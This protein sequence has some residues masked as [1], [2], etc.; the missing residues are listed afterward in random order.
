[1]T[2]RRSGRRRSRSPSSTPRVPISPRCRSCCDRSAPWCARRPPRIRGM[3]NVR[4]SLAFH[5]GVVGAVAT[6]VYTARLERLE[7]KPKHVGLML[8]LQAGLAA[9]QL[10]IAKVMGV[11]PSLVVMFA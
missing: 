11:A 1:T 9:S 6:D 5:L 2:R 4:D 10:E 7:L 8:V 3:A